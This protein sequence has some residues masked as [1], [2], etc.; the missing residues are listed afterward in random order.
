[1]ESYSRAL[2]TFLLW[3]ILSQPFLQPVLQREK[4]VLMV[5]HC[6]LQRRSVT[7]AVRMM[8]IPM[9]LFLHAMLCNRRSQ[10]SPLGIDRPQPHAQRR[11]AAHLANR[12]SQHPSLPLN[13]HQYRVHLEPRTQLLT[14]QG[15]QSSQGMGASRIPMTFK[16]QHSLSM[17]LTCKLFIL[18]TRQVY[19][20]L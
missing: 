17:L 5:P 20:R 19:A 14:S 8:L 11:I 2:T 4:M 13:A 9:V 1:M 15:T 16:V 12:S 18:L 6:V 10:W 3:Q 7:G